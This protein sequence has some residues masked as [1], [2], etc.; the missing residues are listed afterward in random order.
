MAEIQGLHEQKEMLLIERNKLY[1][2]H[3]NK[4][5]TFPGSSELYHDLDNFLNEKHNFV[6]ELVKLRR[7]AVSDLEAAKAG[8]RFQINLPVPQFGL[9]IRMQIEKG[10]LVKENIGE[11]FGF[12]AT[13]FYT[14][15]APFI[16]AESLQKKS[17]DVEF[18]TAQKMKGH[19]IGMLNWLNANYNL[20]NYN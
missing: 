2:L 18:S 16:S 13:H 1:D 5:R 10:L 8:A 11:L 15:N 9:F 17:T 12:F 20:S 3:L 19:L 14:A 4:E 7:E 6:K